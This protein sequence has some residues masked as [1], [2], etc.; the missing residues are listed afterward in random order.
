LVKSDITIYLNQCPKKEIRFVLTVAQIRTQLMVPIMQKLIA[1]M[2]PLSLGLVLIVYSWYQGYPLMID[3]P[4]DFVFNHISV[5]YWLGLPLF[6]GSL[7]VTANL[8]K[9][10]NIKFMTC[11]GIAVG[12]YSLRFFY[13]SLPGSDAHS[14]RGLAE[15]ATAT[16]DLDWSKPSHSYYQ[17]PLLFILSEISSSVVGLELR[18]FEFLMFAV[19]GVLYTASLYVYAAKFSGDGSTTAVITYFLTMYWFLNY[20]FAPFSVAMGLLFVLFMLEVCTHGRYETA[21]ASVVL[22]TGIVFLHPFAGAFYILYEL[23]RYVIGRDEHNLHLFLLSS[24]IYLATSIFLTPVFFPTVVRQLTHPYLSEYPALVERTFGGRMAPP[25][26]IDAIAQEFSRAIVITSVVITG[27][28]FVLLFLKRKLRQV[29]VALLVSSALFAAAASIVPIMGRR[30][31]FA[32]ALP[33]S[34]GATF[35]LKGKTGNAFRLVFLLLAVLFPFIPLTQSFDDDQIMFQTR[36]E[37]ECASFLVGYY[38]WSKTGSVLS[39]YSLMRYLR[40]ITASSHASFRHDLSSSFPHNFS[41]YDCILYTVG[42]GKRLLPYNLTVQELPWKDT[43]DKVYDSDYCHVAV[44][45]DKA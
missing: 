40:T 18:Y 43:H 28:G 26:E 5:S 2:L 33:A 17:W 7:Y 30:V 3:T 22:F 29:D 23:A 14:V 1:V 42:L 24:S 10:H 39:H 35:F 32:L 45:A 38:D 36:A 15:Y 16:N 12:M 20:Q 37:Y 11:L 9:N 13:Y 8:V 31:F 6:L 27:L 34:L 44:K 41:D 19:L 21:L 4:Y 25:P